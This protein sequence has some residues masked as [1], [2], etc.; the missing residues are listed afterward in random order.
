MPDPFH[1]AIMEFIASM[2]A[3]RA[4]GQDLA[5]TD[6]LK[7]AAETLSL[8]AAV[9][10]T[11]TRRPQCSEA[12]EKLARTA[13]PLRSMSPGAHPAEASCAGSSPPRPHSVV[14]A[15]RP[16]SSRTVRSRLRTR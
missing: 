3:V 2:A 4:A 1:D 7:A 15:P 8:L 6:A 10:D 11:E 9:G 13:H 5:V 12:P 16:A 14:R